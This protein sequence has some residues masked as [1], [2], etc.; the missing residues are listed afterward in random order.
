MKTPENSLSLSQ[1][2]KDQNQIIQSTKQNKTQSNQTKINEDQ[3]KATLTKLQTQLNKNQKCLND[4]IQKKGVSHWLKVYPISDQR[5]D[6]NKQFWDCVC[7]HYGKRLIKI[8]STCSCRSKVDIQYA[9]SSK[10]GW[11]MMIRHNDLTVN[12]LTEVCKDV[13]IEPH[14]MFPVLN[15][16][17]FEICLWF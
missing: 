15:R 16:P 1:L 4:I 17:R 11:F 12:L 14:R 7:L 3:C 9:M 13:N 5:Y 2:I 10:K 8:Q 6:L